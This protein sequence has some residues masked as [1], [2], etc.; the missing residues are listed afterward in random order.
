L[1]FLCGKEMEQFPLKDA[2]FIIIHF[3]AVAKAPFQEIPHSYQR[4]G[5]FFGRDRSSTPDEDGL[6][7]GQAIVLPVRCAQN[8]R[9]GSTAFLTLVI[10]FVPD[11][12]R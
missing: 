8:C 6:C 9:L 12:M 7:S 5:A 3:P 1:V 2:H 11:M 4:D 10:C